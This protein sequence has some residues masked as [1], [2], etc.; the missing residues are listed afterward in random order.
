MFAL[1]VTIAS[2]LLSVETTHGLLSGSGNEN[3]RVTLD[4]LSRKSPVYFKLKD[5]EISNCRHVAPACHACIDNCNFFPDSWDISQ[6]EQTVETLKQV[7]SCHAEYLDRKAGIPDWCM[8]DGHDFFPI[9]GYEPT[10]EQC[11][12]MNRVSCTRRWL[13]D[14]ERDVQAGKLKKTDAAFRIA[15]KAQEHAE[16]L[17]SIEHYRSELDQLPSKISKYG[18]EKKRKLLTQAYRHIAHPDEDKTV[19]AHPMYVDME[20]TIAEN[21]RLDLYI[22]RNDIYMSSMENKF[23]RRETVDQIPAFLDAISKLES[24]I[25]SKKADTDAYLQDIK[26]ISERTAVFQGKATNLMYETTHATDVDGAIELVDKDLF[27]LF[28]VLRTERSILNSANAR[29][30]YAK[31]RLISM[32]RRLVNEISKQQLQTGCNTNDIMSL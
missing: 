29:A 6:R 12:L 9:P 21:R 20:K 2:L 30:T 8:N 4:F 18:D 32:L 22:S 23:V 27:E 5:G 15:S 13:A 1:A 17:D 14:M 31:I 7:E 16:I 19:F 28:T 3:A 24:H 26:D 25:H 10:G 11:N